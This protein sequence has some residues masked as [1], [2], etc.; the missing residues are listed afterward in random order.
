MIEGQ[1]FPHSDQALDIFGEKFIVDKELVY[2]YVKAVIVTGLD[3][4]EVY[5]GDDLIQSFP[6]KLPHPV[7]N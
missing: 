1:L 3:T 6:Y 7:Y 4:L 2:A 5:H